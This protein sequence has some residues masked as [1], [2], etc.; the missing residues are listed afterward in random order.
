M[1]LGDGMI[2]LKKLIAVIFKRKNSSQKKTLYQEEYKANRRYEDSTSYN[3][4]R[5]AHR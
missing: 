5:L 1:F 3:E 2:F 4:A